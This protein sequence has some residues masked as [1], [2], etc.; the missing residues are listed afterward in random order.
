MISGCFSERRSQTARPD[1]AGRP[2]NASLQGPRG[3]PPSVENNPG[4][5]HP[6]SG[7]SRQPVELPG[8]AHPMEL[9]GESALP[10][11]CDA[12]C[13][14]WQTPERVPGR[15]SCVPGLGREDGLPG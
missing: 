14:A 9:P 11:R 7:G 5:S 1:T 13:S 3:R 8:G 15:L 10:S 6:L 2:G 4:L 12:R